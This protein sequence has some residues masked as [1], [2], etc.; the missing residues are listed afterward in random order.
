MVQNS[1]RSAIIL[2]V[3]TVMAKLPRVHNKYHNTAPEGAVYIGRPSVWGNPFSVQEHGR[4]KALDLYHNWLWA[5]EQNGLREKAMKELRGKDL[6]CFCA[7]KPCHGDTLLGL[8]N[9]DWSKMVIT[10]KQL[11]EEEPPDQEEWDRLL[12]Q[13]FINDSTPVSPDNNNQE[14]HDTKERRQGS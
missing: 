14:T 5:P 8:A 3:E 2:F 6:V 11:L 13:M 9:A 4:D 12:R 10:G 1:V 7:P